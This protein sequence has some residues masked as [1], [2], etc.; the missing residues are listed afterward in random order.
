M[1]CQTWCSCKLEQQLDL[2]YKSIKTVWILDVIYPLLYHIYWSRE[3]ITQLCTQ[4]MLFYHSYMYFMV[5][6]HMVY[7]IIWPEANPYNYFKCI[8]VAYPGFDLGGGRKSL[9]VLKVEVKACFSLICI[10]IM[11]KT[12]RERRKKG[13]NSVLGIIKQS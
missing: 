3:D 11:L 13:K 1:V 7:L 4:M 5:C 2:W 10:K 6:Y 9:K 8:P 12:N